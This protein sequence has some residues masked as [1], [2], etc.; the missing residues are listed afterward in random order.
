MVDMV[1]PRYGDGIDVLDLEHNQLGVRL[2]IFLGEDEDGNYIGDPP[3]LHVDVCYECYNNSIRGEEDS[4]L[5]TMWD[6]NTI[7]NGK[8]VHQQ[9]TQFDL[10]VGRR[11]FEEIFADGEVWEWDEIIGASDV[12]REDGYNCNECQEE[13][14][15]ACYDIGS[16][17]KDRPTIWHMELNKQ[18][19]V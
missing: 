6:K 2:Y 5:P 1:Y 4:W 8:R 11:T 16:G 15:N 18:V 10:A 3:N 7:L 19:R 13:L 12:F 14:L 17:G 9:V